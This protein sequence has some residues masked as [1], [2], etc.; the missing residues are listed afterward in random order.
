MWLQHCYVPICFVM[1]KLFY[2]IL[3]ADFFILY[4]I[5]SSAVVSP[6]LDEQSS[7]HCC[8]EGVVT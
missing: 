2:L 5:L 7:G 6:Y 4:M 8:P 3:Y 1:F